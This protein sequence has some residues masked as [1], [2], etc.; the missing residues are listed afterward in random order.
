MKGS[1][2][3]E[4]I[5]AHDNPF[6][7]SQGLIARAQ[8]GVGRRPLV[9]KWQHNDLQPSVPQFGRQLDQELIGGVID[10]AAYRVHNSHRC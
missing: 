9:I 4:F 8:L 6:G 5:P 10:N 1:P 3:M 2:L 7:N